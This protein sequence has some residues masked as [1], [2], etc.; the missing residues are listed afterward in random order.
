M[1]SLGSDMEKKRY[2]DNF[3]IVKKFMHFTE[4]PDEFYFVQVLYRKKDNTEIAENSVVLSDKSNATRSIK[5][6]CITSVDLLTRLEFEIK[7]LCKT[8]NARAYFY[9]AKRSFKQ[10][11]LKNLLELSESIATENYSHV[12][13]KYWSAC[14][15]VSIEKFYLVDIDENHYNDVDLSEI[16]K[17]IEYELKSGAEQGQRILLKVPTKHGIH[18]ICRPFDVKSFSEKWSDISIQKSNPTV[19]FCIL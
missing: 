3:E 19:L 7:Q 8:F 17:T 12:K 10:V 6:Y 13:S 14:G 2:V 18:F 4:N 5:S 16:E 15:K 9:P 11:A 1:N